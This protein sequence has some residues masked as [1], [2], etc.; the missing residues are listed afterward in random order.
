MFDKPHH[1]RI[2]KILQ[3]LNVPFLQEAACYF[4]GGTAIVLALDEYRESRDIDFLCASREGYRLLRSTVS[5]HSLGKL[6]TKPIPL[7]REIRADRYG[8][9]TQLEVDGVPIKIEFVGEARI[10]IGGELDATTGI[11]TLSRTDL[12]AEKLLAN[13]D[14][15]L[16]R[17]TL[18]RDII[19]LAMMIH[20]WGDIPEQALA[21]AQAAYGNDI[22]RAWRDSTKM[23]AD[24]RYLKTCLERMQMDEALAP[25]IFAALQGSRLMPHQEG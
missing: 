20:H 18:S 17:S 15:G 21:K 2:Q 4:G 8:I 25:Q 3:A 6:L 11:P 16:D 14:R 12:F 1:E 22:A 13:A 9:R 19:D 24:E 5:S 10:D 7:L 23:L